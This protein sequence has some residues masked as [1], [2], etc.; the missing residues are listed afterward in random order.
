MLA[1]VQGFDEAVALACNHLAAAGGRLSAVIVAVN[2][3]GFLKT[4]PFLF[5]FAWFWHRPPAGNRDQVLRGIM[6]AVLTFAAGRA[7]QGLLPFRPRPI[8]AAALGLHLPP[9]LALGALGGWNSMP[10]DHGVLFA[11]LAVAVLAISRRAGIACVAYALLVVLAPRVYLGEHYVSDVLAGA[12]VGVAGALACR[13][14]RPVGAAAAALLALE[15][16]HPAAWNAVAL[17]LLVQLSQMFND[18]RAFA[19]LLTH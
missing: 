18:V 1:T 14:L 3:S 10:S 12:A 16:R 5:A 19:G 13:R 6:A 9:G 11:A 4:A 15:R 2:D 8:H 7:L 17:L